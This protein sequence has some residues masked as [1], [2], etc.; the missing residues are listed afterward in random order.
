[1]GDLHYLCLSGQILST[2]ERTLE[3]VPQNVFQQTLLGTLYLNE[4][5]STS[6]IDLCNF[7]QRTG[8]NISKH[9]EA[10]E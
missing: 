9:D 10:Y 3:E 8:P 6:F 2:D 4:C 5:I 1:M 7:H